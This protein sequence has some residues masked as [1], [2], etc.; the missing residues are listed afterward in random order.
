MRIITLVPVGRVE[1]GHLESLAQ[2]LASRLRVACWIRPDGPDGEFAYNPVRGQYHSTEI[3]KRLLQDPPAESWRILG[4]TDVDLYIPILTFVFG[5]AQLGDSGALVS[6]HRLRPE[7]YG[8]PKDPEL[9]RERLL[10]E[11]LHELGHTFGLRHC[12]DYLC[13]MST[14]HSVER[15]DLKQA[16]FC[17]ACTGA[18]GLM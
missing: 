10:K 11:A 18:A 5:E 15:I 13:V 14:A 9:L 12:P 6:T 8:M 3:L 16:D 17:M 2:G 7:F 1:R 4:V